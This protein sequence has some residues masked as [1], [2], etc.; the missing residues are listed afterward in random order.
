MLDPDCNDEYSVIHSGGEKVSIL[1]NTPQESVLIRERA[2]SFPVIPSNKHKSG[3]G[4]GFCFFLF[5]GGGV[6][7]VQ[8]CA[9]SIIFVQTSMIAFLQKM[10]CL[11]CNVCMYLSMNVCIL[12]NVCYGEQFN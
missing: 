2:V 12:C 5:L 8:K 6:H 4:S 7:M 11:A 9:M 10:Y 1:W 3:V